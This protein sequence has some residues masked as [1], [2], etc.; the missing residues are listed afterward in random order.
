MNTTITTKQKRTSSIKHMSTMQEG[1]VP[2]CIM[3]NLTQKH[4]KYWTFTLIDVIFNTFLRCL[5]WC[6]ITVH[7]YSTS[8]GSTEYWCPRF[9]LVFVEKL[10][11]PQATK[12]IELWVGFDTGIHLYYIAAHKIAR[13][14]NPQVSSALPF[15]HAFTGC[16]TVSCFYGKGKKTAMDTWKCFPAVTTTLDQCKNCHQW[17]L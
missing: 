16:D 12:K 13:K 17:C 9:S 8:I 11:E 15:F 2:N 10:Q 6:E 5:F 7:Q 4:L 1:D 14:L 3:G